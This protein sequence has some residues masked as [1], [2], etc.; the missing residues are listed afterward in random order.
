MSE[1]ATQKARAIQDLVK[2]EGWTIL[3]SE[4]RRE[5]AQAVETMRQIDI[6]GRPLQDIGA[7]FV[8]QQKL[9]DGLNRTLELVTELQEPLEQ[10]N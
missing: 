7:E 1:Q 3:E 9:I 10:A 8:E 2:M 5:I 6:E 4:I